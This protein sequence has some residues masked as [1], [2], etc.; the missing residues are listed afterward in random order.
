MSDL[1]QYAFAS[2]SILC[3]SLSPTLSNVLSVHTRSYVCLYSHTMN[4]NA[5]VA[6]AAKIPLLIFDFIS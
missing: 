6:I 5:Q 4:V 1:N 2:N 3:N